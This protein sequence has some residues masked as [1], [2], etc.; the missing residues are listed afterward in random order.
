MNDWLLLVAFRP[1]GPALSSLPRQYF[2]LT[3]NSP[4]SPGTGKFPR[5]TKAHP[6]Y[7]FGRAGNG[8]WAENLYVSG[9]SDRR[10]VSLLVLLS[11]VEVHLGVSAAK[12]D[13]AAVVVVATESEKGVLDMNAVHVSC[14]VLAPELAIIVSALATVDGLALAVAAPAKMHLLVSLR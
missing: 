6:Q 1:K 8:R 4:P 7:L 3:K 2:V 10:A 11:K 12:S 14:A 5:P 13:C 9:P